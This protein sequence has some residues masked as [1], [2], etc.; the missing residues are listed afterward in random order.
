MPLVLAA[1]SALDSDAPG[2]LRA[3]GA[4]GFD[5]CGLRLS[6]EHGDRPEAIAA[7]AQAAGIAVHDAEV[8]RI[9]ADRTDP[10][11]L[12]AAAALAGAAALLVVSDLADRDATTAAV[13]DLVARADRHGLTVGLE[14]MAWTD[15]STPADTMA[16]A[17]R[18]GCV[19]VVDV[20]HHI[21]VGGGP[22]ELAEV[23]ASGHFGWLQLCD[24]LLTPPPDLLDEARH[25]RLPPGHGQLPLRQL[26]DVVPDDAVISVEVQSD[27][28][29]ALD[30]DTRARL[31]AAAARAVLGDGPSR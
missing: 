7:A 28:L 30:V 2:L 6:G 17:A 21:R 23:V 1:G 26:L 27:A 10:E 29:L 4:A 14:Y 25:R 11:P 18:T 8:H 3:A 12:L 15:P 20:L 16:V 22:A 13:A 19:V 5:G 31:L 24:A 9:T